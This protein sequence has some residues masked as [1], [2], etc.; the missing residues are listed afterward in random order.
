MNQ[1]TQAPAKVFIDPRVAF[2]LPASK[3]DAVEGQAGGTDEP[4]A[5]IR[6]DIYE[7]RLRQAANVNQEIII[8]IQAVGATLFGLSNLGRLFAHGVPLD[9]GNAPAVWHL[10]TEREL[11]P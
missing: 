2:R 11:A 1:P 10:I 7:E 6:Q 9:A 4:V 8:S 3:G 5:Y